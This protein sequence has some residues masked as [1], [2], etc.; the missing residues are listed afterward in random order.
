MG[1][2]SLNEKYGS[3]L[4]YPKYGALNLHSCHDSR[5]ENFL[6][7]PLNSYV[8]I[9]ELGDLFIVSEEMYRYLDV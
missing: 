4:K 2:D 7:R 3:Y 5:I 8:Y 6:N 9:M 1:H